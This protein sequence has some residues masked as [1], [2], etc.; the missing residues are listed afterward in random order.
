VGNNILHHTEKRKNILAN[1]RLELF[2]GMKGINT[3]DRTKFH[4]TLGNKREHW[5][6]QEKYT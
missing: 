2:F 6:E 4:D 5:R 3:Y 1:K